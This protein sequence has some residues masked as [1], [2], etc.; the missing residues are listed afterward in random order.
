MT[1]LIY[2]NLTIIYSCELHLQTIILYYSPV[3]ELENVDQDNQKLEIVL[4][5][6]ENTAKTL[7]IGMN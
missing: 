5:D 3:L 7:L 2:S 4:R 1:N 6:I